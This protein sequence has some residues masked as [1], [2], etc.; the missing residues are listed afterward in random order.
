MKEVE[1]LAPV[2]VAA[3]DHGFDAIWTIVLPS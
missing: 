1:R 2:P 3:P